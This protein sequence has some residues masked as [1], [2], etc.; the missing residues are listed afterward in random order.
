MNSLLARFFE[1]VYLKEISFHVD[2]FSWMTHA[3]TFRMDKFLQILVD[4]D[5]KIFQ[6]NKNNSSFI[7][8]YAW[9]K[10][11]QSNVVIKIITN[12]IINK[13][14]FL[15][16]YQ[17]FRRDIFPQIDWIQTFHRV[18]F[19]QKWKLEIA[20]FHAKIYFPTVWHLLTMV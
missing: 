17:K 14:G 19:L 6:G 10:V 13:K 2:I 3:Q 11:C 12:E 16:F 18:I 20:K 5:K 4:T 1:I 15:L 8:T 9:N 7:K